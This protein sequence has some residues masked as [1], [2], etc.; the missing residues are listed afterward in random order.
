MLIFVA[1]SVLLMPEIN[2]LRSG[3]CRD[4]LLPTKLPRLS[5]NASN[6]NRLS[7]ACQNRVTRAGRQFQETEYHR[8]HL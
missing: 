3:S 1:V 7:L 6:L 4:E 8:V 5:V 2:S